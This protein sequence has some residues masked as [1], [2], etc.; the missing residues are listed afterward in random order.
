MNYG[1]HNTERHVAHKPGSVH[2]TRMQ[3]LPTPYAAL[4][5]ISLRGLRHGPRR[6]LRGCSR[7]PVSASHRQR[8]NARTTDSEIAAGRITLFT[9]MSCPTGIVSVALTRRAARPC[10]RYRRSGTVGSL[11]P[12]PA[13]AGH[14]AH[15]LPGLSS[16]KPATIRRHASIRLSKS[17]T[18]RYACAAG[19]SE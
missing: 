12:T 17:R 11:A 6:H 15:M 16:G 2:A 19:K 7:L 3:A 1:H 4:M 8:A 10:P 13:F 14:P 18:R 5:V 9:P